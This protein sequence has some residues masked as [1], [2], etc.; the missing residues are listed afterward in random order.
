[1]KKIIFIF[2]PSCVGK[3]TIAKLLGRKFPN[4]LRLSADQI[5][6]SMYHYDRSNSL[7][8]GLRNKFFEETLNLFLMSGLGPIICE[9]PRSQLGKFYKI[10]LTVDF[11][12]FEAK[13]VSLDAPDDIL[14]ERFNNRQTRSKEQGFT[15]AVSTEDEFLETVL[16]Y[17]RLLENIVHIPSEGV[18][19]SQS[20]AEE[21]VERILNDMN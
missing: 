2:G 7:H 17:R 10:S 21:I 18:D 5:R 8:E 19:T 9:V 15:L 1:M 16:E 14:V 4:A 12:K 11:A 13:Y 20:T 3:S 6:G